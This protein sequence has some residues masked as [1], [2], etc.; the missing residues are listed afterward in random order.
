MSNVNEDGIVTPDE[1]NNVDPDVWSAAMADSISEGIGVRLKKQET[2]IG[3]KAGIAAGTTAAYASGLIAPYEILT[4]DGCFTEGL[5]LTGGIATVAVEG[6][7]LLSASAS[8][9]S[10]ANASSNDQRTIALQIFKNTSQLTGA[11]VSSTTGHWATASATTI[12]RCVPG[13]TLHVEWY[14]AGPVAGE[15]EGTLSPNTAM[16][17]LSIVLVTPTPSVPA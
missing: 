4:S 5:T 3:L 1:E 10:V 2:A 12:V 16:N 8:L 7:Y 14:S 15:G 17:S 9:E 11:E 6:M 13:D